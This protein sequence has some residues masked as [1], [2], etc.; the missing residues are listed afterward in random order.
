MLNFHTHRPQ[1]DE[2]A[3]RS[4]GLHPW[5]L[6]V[7]TLAEELCQ[8]ESQLRVG[9]YHLVGECGIDHCCNTPIP[10]QH[11]AFW[12]QLQLAEMYR[13]PVVVHCV[14]A[15]DELLFFRRQPLATIAQHFSLSAASPALRQSWQQTWVVHGFGGS[16]QLAEKLQHSGILVSFGAALLDERRNKPRQALLALG[17]ELVH[18]HHSAQHDKALPAASFF[19]ETDDSTCSIQEIYQAAASLLQ[20]PVPILEQAIDQAFATLQQSHPSSI[21]S[22]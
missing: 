8:M 19:L 3:T 21:N 12:R 10:L 15:Y 9:C 20:L 16:A 13:L 7:E 18:Y 22:L 5:H 14:H 2:T 17:A 11:E 6:S 4:I 1:T